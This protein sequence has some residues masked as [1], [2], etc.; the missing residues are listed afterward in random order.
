MKLDKAFLDI[1]ILNNQI[2]LQKGEAE[3]TGSYVL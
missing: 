2:Q 3:H 1:E